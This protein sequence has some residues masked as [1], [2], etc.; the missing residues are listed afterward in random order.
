VQIKIWG[1][2]TYQPSTSIFQHFEQSQFGRNTFHPCTLNLGMGC[3]I[4]WPPYNRHQLMWP[5]KLDNFLMATHCNRHLLS[6]LRHSFFAKFCTWVLTHPHLPDLHTIFWNDAEHWT[7]SSQTLS[8]A[9]A[10]VK[11]ANLSSSTTKFQP[12]SYFINLQMQRKIIKSG[13]TIMF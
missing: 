12:F 8:V 4:G 7:F 11:W 2:Y 9:M 5:L 3:C 13:V 6:L 10:S 1:Q